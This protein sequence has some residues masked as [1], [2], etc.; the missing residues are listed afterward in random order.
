[1]IDQPRC[2]RCHAPLTHTEQTYYGLSCDHCELDYSYV[3]GGVK[4]YD[5]WKRFTGFMLRCLL[6]AAW[7]WQR[8]RRTAAKTA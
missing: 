8:A 5:Y 3:L 7:H 4:N 6:P 1:M 2:C